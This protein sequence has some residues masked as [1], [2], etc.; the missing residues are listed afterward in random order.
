MEFARIFVTSLRASFVGRGIGAIGGRRW[1]R[2]ACRFGRLHWSSLS[3][4]RALPVATGF[5]SAASLAC[6]RLRSAGNTHTP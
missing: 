6:G 4:R 3:Q 5:G 2:E 1:E